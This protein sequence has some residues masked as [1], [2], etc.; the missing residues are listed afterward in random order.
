MYMHNFAGWSTPLAQSPR[1]P[2]Y[3]S[4][5]GNFAAGLRSRVFEYKKD[6]AAKFGLAHPTISRYEYGDHPP[7]PGYLAGLAC[8]VVDNLRDPQTIATYKESLLNDINT[9]VR[10]NRGKKIYASVPFF[11]DWDELKQFA[12]DYLKNRERSEALL[13]FA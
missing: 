5:L 4:T 1:P 13:K 9:A 8:L 3:D 12:D 10:N 7:P 2:K 11:Q 6:A